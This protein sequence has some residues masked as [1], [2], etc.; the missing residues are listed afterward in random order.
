MLTG[1]Q[2]VAGAVSFLIFVGLIGNAIYQVINAVRPHNGTKFEGPAQTGT[3]EILS[4]QGGLYFGGRTALCRIGLRV[5][6]PGHPPY[7][8]T[9]N[10][11]ADMGALAAMQRPGA[12]VG[13]EV[14]STNPQR[15]RIDFSQPMPMPQAGWWGSHPPAPAGMNY[16]EHPPFNAPQPPP[17]SPY[18]Y[19]SPGMRMYIR[20][21]WLIVG[22]GFVA[23]V[24]ALVV[25]GI[26]DP[27]LVVDTIV[28][29]V[30]HR[31]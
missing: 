8:V 5:E 28:E 18:G 3:A 9:V 13:V 14:D 1:W 23:A 17:G 20:V 19:M 29:K 15:V 6:I 11:R 10:T 12:T 30:F 26:H 22:F 2:Y 25:A 27:K 16:G 21:M 7:D 4:A 24:V 31:G